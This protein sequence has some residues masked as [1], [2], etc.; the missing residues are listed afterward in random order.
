MINISRLYCGQP[1]GG[2]GL[3]YGSAAERRDLAKGGQDAAGAGQE[4]ASSAGRRRPVV[5]WNITR[6]CNL[7]CIHCYTNSDLTPADDEL[8]TEEAKLVLDDLA[9]F[10]VPVVL[11]SGGEPLMRRDL[12]ELAGY[13]GKLGLR[14]VFSTNGTL[15]TANVSKKIRQNGVSYVGVSLDGI[16]KANDRFRGVAGAFEKAAAGIRHCQDAG[17]RVG[18]RFTLTMQNLDELEKVFEFLQAQDIERACF[19]HLV[20]TGAAGTAMYRV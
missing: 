16:G 5:V 12:F 19:Y 2:D 20:P 11:F 6:A 18:I 14:T 13:A 7:R 8:S 4:A 9:K 10:S 17:V 3:R 1:T 15:I